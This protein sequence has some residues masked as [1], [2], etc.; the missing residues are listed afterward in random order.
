MASATN[1]NKPSGSGTR[2]SAANESQQSRQEQSVVDRTVRAASGVPAAASAPVR[3][4]AQGLQITRNPPAP[5]VAPNPDYV[6][7]NPPAP[8][9]APAAPVVAPN[10]D[11]VNY[12]PPAPVIAPA[13]APVPAPVYAP[14]PQSVLSEGARRTVSFIQDDS[15]FQFPNGF[16]GFGSAKESRITITL[17]K[18]IVLDTIVH[19]ELGL[20]LSE[21][22][23]TAI[24]KANQDT[25]R[26]GKI[27]FKEDGWVYRD[28]ERLIECSKYFYPRQP[29]VL[30]WL[31]K[32]GH[33]D[34]EKGSF[35]ANDYIWGAQ[36]SASDD[37]RP[38]RGKDPN[39]Q[40]HASDY[41]RGPAFPQKPSSQKKEKESDY[42]EYQS[43]MSDYEV[44]NRSKPDAPQPKPD[45]KRD[46]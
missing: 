12:N 15:G 14:D 7:Y 29:E 38:M 40:L 17:T 11:Y 6:N 2:S 31:I 36:S 21:N 45:S 27:T 41:E 10:P 5:V 16:G 3:Q 32:E 24:H 39:A 8:V 33:W 30:K 22:T 23:R 46:K 20:H 35:S 42:S 28:G 37:Y 4:P 43:T 18:A 1:N 19:D 44:P 13:P 26:L 25:G 34:G 9:I